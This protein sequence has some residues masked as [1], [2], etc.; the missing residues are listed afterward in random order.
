[1]EEPQPQ[2]P[3]TPDWSNKTLV[4]VMLII[5]GVFT[6]IYLTQKPKVDYGTLQYLNTQ[7]DSLR[8]ASR[9]KDKLIVALQRDINRVT[10]T[11]KIIEKK[12]TIRYDNYIQS[13]ANLRPDSTIDTSFAAA[14]LRFRERWNS[15]VFFE[16]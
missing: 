1:M 15:G 11:I 6:I 16:R 3:K 5:A 2:F 8:G 9:E 4:G 13:T 14:R 10:D 12:Q 7:A